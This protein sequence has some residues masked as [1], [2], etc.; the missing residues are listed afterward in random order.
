VRFLI[1]FL[2][3]LLVVPV[4]AQDGSKPVQAG[5][6]P[7]GRITYVLL[8]NN[9]IFD[10][11]DPELDTRFVWAYRA[12]NALHLRTRPWVIRRELLFR[13]GD[14]FDP[15]LLAESERLLRAYPFLARVDIHAVPS[16]TAPGT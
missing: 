8:D 6:C 1:P 12:A 5:E 11:S 3:A 16:R 10:T 7:N 4:Y 13:T 15:F 9:S 14:C 2:S